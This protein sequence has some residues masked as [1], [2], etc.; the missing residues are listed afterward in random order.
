MTDIIPVLSITQIE[1]TPT[2]LVVRGNVP[3]DVWLAY[4]EGL[5]RVDAAVDWALGDWLVLG[6]NAYGET[7]SQAMAMWPEAKYKTLANA[8]SVA[9]RVERSRRKETLSWSH[10][11]AVARLEPE[12]QVHWLAQAEANGWTVRELRA[13]IR[14]EPE[15]ED[16]D[17]CPRCGS[18]REHW[19]TG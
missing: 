8:K 19:R 2:G 6:E 7:Y 12:D 15:P 5:Q 9:N 14:G 4:G 10:H 18:E 17:I 1:A 16:P 3:F 13:Q 11:E